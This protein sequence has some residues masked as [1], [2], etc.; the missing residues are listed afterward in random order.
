[1]TIEISSDLWGKKWVIRDSWTDAEAR[2]VLASGIS[3]VEIHGFGQSALPSLSSLHGFAELVVLT[4]N[5]MS[6]TAVTELTD[7]SALSLET[8][9]RDQI[10]FRV[11]KRLERLHL[12][13]RPGAETALENE[14]IRNLS[15]SRYPHTDLRPLAKLVGLQGLRI[16]NAPNLTS[17]AGITELPDLKRLWLIDDR[18]L[19]TVDDLAAGKPALVDLL[20]DACRNVRNVDGLAAQTSLQSVSLLEDGRIAS[21]RPLTSLRD[22]RL[23][24]FYGSTR[25][26]DGDLSLLLDLPNLTFVSFADRRHY[27]HD[28]ASVLRQRGGLSQQAPPSHW[29]W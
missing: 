8:Y 5:I 12:N 18:E 3:R 11:F 10:D 29:W 28:L 25:I 26:E 16:A 20:I 21:L 24:I 13:W 19:A 15:L 23:L 22:L 6:D 7:L 17:L 27:S 2:Q 9:V 1:L 4:L 14:A